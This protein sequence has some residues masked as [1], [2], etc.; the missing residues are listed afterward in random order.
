[1]NGP[2]NK[3]CQILVSISTSSVALKATGPRHYSKQFA[4]NLT[5]S[6]L[7]VLVIACNILK[8]IWIMAVS[9]ILTHPYTDSVTLLDISLD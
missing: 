8:V 3:K 7:V 6:F 2:L 4:E 1:M 9:C 5:I